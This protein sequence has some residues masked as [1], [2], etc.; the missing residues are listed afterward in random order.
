MTREEYEQAKCHGHIWAR[1]RAT[2]TPPV[3][4]EDGMPLTHPD[5]KCKFC[6]V[7]YDAAH[8]SSPT[9]PQSRW[10][11]HESTLKYFLLDRRVIS[12]DS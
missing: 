8:Q 4:R 1:P 3:Y 2:V 5:V 12:C 10:L 9:P 6:G 7:S 11:G